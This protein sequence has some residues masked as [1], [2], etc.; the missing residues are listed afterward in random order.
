MN[1]YTSPDWKRYPFEILALTVFVLAMTVA[2]P[3]NPFLGYTAACALALCFVLGIIRTW[4]R[5]D[6]HQQ[7][8]ERAV[9]DAL[10]N[11]SSGD[12]DIWKYQAELMAISG[13]HMPSR[14]TLHNGVLLYAALNA[15]ELGETFGAIANVLKGVPYNPEWAAGS[16]LASI[17]DALSWLG[18]VSQEQAL[19]IRRHVAELPPGFMVDLGKAEAVEL[20]DGVTDVAVVLAGLGLAA[21]LPVREGYQDVGVSN[22]SKANPVTGVIDKDAGGKWIKGSQYHKPN[23]EAVLAKHYR[24]ANG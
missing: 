4:L 14:P 7:E 6:E 1:R 13:Q 2:D 12:V 17:H 9:D 5:E 10:M 15:E 21:G 18:S 22:L 11:Y 3:D 8:L 20:L 23:L 16:H 19:V 24:V